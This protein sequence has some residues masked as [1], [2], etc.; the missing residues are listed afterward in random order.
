[1]YAEELNYWQTSTV[2]P[3]TWID[4]AKKLIA[5]FGGR[6]IGDAFGADGDGRA[7]FMI[8]FEISG[9][10]FKIVWP[11]LK[12]RSGNEKAARRQAATFIY[13]DVKAKCLSAT[14]LGAR[15]AFFSYLLLPDG[16]TVSEASDSEVIRLLPSIVR[17]ELGTGDEVVEGEYR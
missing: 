4:K 9:D 12:S 5:G 17:L 1:M 13:H 2:S 14:V 16:R 7:A 6:I 10:R 8:A 11:V 15:S 3:D